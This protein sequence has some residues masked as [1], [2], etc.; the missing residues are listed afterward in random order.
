[1]ERLAW[2]AGSGRGFDPVTRMAQKVSQVAER[3]V[4]AGA[5]GRAIALRTGAISGDLGDA[6]LLAPAGQ[7]VWFLVGTSGAVPL[8]MV[9]AR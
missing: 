6:G 9:L 1:L 3:V 5:F 2:I 7:A 8:A 4:L